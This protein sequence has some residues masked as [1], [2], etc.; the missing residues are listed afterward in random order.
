[1]FHGA[2]HADLFFDAPLDLG[3]Q[4]PIAVGA[5][6]IGAAFEPDVLIPRLG[7]PAAL[8]D[9]FGLIDPGG[10]A[11]CGPLVVKDAGLAHEH[12]GQL[13]Q[14]LGGEPLKIPV[15]LVVAQPHGEGIHLLRPQGL[16]GQRADQL[17]ILGGRRC[18]SAAHILLHNFHNSLLN[19]S[20]WA[21]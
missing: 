14:G 1:M 21:R 4:V 8:P 3:D 10:L 9:D 15:D 5:H 16:P 17:Q 11:P 12:G 13:L 6:H 18:L 2:P 7:H 20:A 19:F